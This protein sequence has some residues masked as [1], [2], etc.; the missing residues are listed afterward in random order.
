MSWQC[1]LCKGGKFLCGKSRCPIIVKQYA[2][3]QLA[4]RLDA[5]ELEGASPP[6]VFIGSFNYPKIFVGPLVPP[7][8]GDTYE[9]DLPELWGD[10]TIDEIVNFRF[11]L[12]RG[13]Q[14]VDVHDVESANKIIEHTRE[15]ALAK[16]PVEADV[17]F[18]K[19]P[20]QHIVMGDEIQPFGP[21]APLRDFDVQNV[22]FDQRIGK[23]HYD[24]DLKAAPAVLDL[25]AAGLEV[26]RIQ[27]AF[28]VGAFG[29]GKDRKFVPTRWSIT[30]V[31]S[32]LS[33]D[34][35]EHTKQ[36]PVI[37]EYH[38][39][40]HTQLDNRWIVLMMP[41][42]WCY[43]LIEAW[44]P[45]TVWNPDGT[46]IVMLADHEKYSGRKTYP[47]IGGCYF[48]A[49]L[50]VNEKLNEEHRQA[51]I[52]ILREAHPGYI[53]P[54]G[55][56]CV[57]ESV[58]AALRKNPLKFDTLNQALLRVAEVMDI[59]LQRW[60]RKSTL[61]RDVLYQKRLADYGN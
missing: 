56:W 61:L 3:N 30:A 40:E 41:Q 11:S 52:V 44:Y 25:Y 46:E 57:R 34:L 19:K 45:N 15:I 48:A 1:A 43:E 55:V 14:L 16:R 29:L 53:M 5:L 35:I 50:A 20:V 32:L 60:V 24:T 39:Y 36:N 27:K 28:S 12:V 51:S 33:K 42:P 18:K 26:T 58:R 22:K 49:R 4:P 10:K 31:D 37:N 6:S 21:S 17:L 2:Q 7:V 8:H 38:V 47:D 59:P 54:V 9:Y 13:K 23:A